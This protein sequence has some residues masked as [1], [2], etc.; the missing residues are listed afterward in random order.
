MKNYHVFKDF[1]EPLDECLFIHSLVENIKNILAR[2]NIPQFQWTIDSIEKEMKII[3]FIQAQK[4][5]K[6]IEID[7]KKAISTLESYRNQKNQVAKKIIFAYEERNLQNYKNVLN[8]I[9][10][11]KEMKK[12]FSK[13]CEI[14]IS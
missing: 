5:L 4:I 8:Q 13:I 9:S 7:F 6:Q 2:Y 14:I 11:F 3:K 12:E 10:D 1:C